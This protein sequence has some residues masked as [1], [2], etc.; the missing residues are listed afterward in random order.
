MNSLE[1]I[2]GVHKVLLEEL[3]FKDSGVLKWNMISYF[4]PNHNEVEMTEWKIQ[5]PSI[6]GASVQSAQTQTLPNTQNE[7]FGDRTGHFQVHL[8]L[9]L[10]VTWFYPTKELF[11]S[12]NCM[13]T[14]ESLSFFLVH[15]CQMPVS[16]SDGIS[17]HYLS[18]SWAGTEC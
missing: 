2:M 16:L 4:S 1:T 8:S 3:F 5:T 11:L 10:Q 13:F 17:G 7:K 15:F 12:P 14:L 18:S 9:R 6:Q